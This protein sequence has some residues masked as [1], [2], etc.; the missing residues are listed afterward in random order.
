MIFGAV[1]VIAAWAVVLGLSIA[2]KAALFKYAP[3]RDVF[4]NACH[5]AAQNFSMTTIKSSGYVSVCRKFDKRDGD[6]R[7]LG[8]LV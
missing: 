1:V 5:V 4:Q 8:L 7:I 3:P 6:T 2:A